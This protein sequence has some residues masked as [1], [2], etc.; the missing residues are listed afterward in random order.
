MGSHS[1][2]F[3]ARRVS[4]QPWK[5]RLAALTVASKVPMTDA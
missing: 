4:V 3:S 5:D 1:S 2:H